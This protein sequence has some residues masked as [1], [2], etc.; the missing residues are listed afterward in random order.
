MHMQHSAATGGSAGYSGQTATGPVSGLTFSQIKELARKYSGRGWTPQLKACFLDHLAGKGSVRAACARVGISP[1]AAYRLRRRDAL[2]ARGWAAALVLA[3][4]ASVQVL[5]DRAIDGVAEPIWHRGEQVGTRRRYD[6]RLLL[7]HIGRLD[8][9]ADEERGAEDAG[10]FDELIARIAGEELPEGLPSRDGIIPHDRERAGNR[11]EADAVR[12]TRWAAEEEF[13]ELAAHLPSNDDEEED[14]EYD[15]YYG[16]SEEER[17]EREAAE[18][19]QRA[20]EEHQLEVEER[21]IAEGRRGRAEAE[22]GW[23]AW[24]A[25]ACDAVDKAAGRP[26]SSPAGPPPAPGL[27]GSPFARPEGAKG[28]A[29]DAEKHG[30]FFSPGTV[31]TP[32]TPPP[33]AGPGAML[34][35]SPSAL[36]LG[37]AG[38]RR[39]ALPP[40]AHRPNSR[41]HR[42]KARR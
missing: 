26:P 15:E 17:L 11:A 39:F 8:R 24:F 33:A 14:D 34:T 18:A 16:E 40:F 7:A 27:P 9:L 13:A 23:D 10:R 41:V 28:R 22:A 21:C 35:A 36:A 6:A 1:E 5:A 31:S 25:R 3:R 37:L 30:E 42:Q 19:A 12:Q 4:D 20:V 2:F 29:K 32:S 38:P